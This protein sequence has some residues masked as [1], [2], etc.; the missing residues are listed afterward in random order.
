MAN[1][2]VLSRPNYAAVATNKPNRGFRAPNYSFRFKSLILAETR[3][4]KS[5][6]LK[7]KV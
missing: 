5:F 6:R 4:A 3:L 2:V 1:T 7:S